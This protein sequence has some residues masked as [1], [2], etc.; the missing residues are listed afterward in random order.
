LRALRL[1]GS[2]LVSARTSLAPVMTALIAFCSSGD[3]GVRLTTCSW[4]T[5]GPIRSRIF[6]GSRPTLCSAEN[7]SMSSPRTIDFTR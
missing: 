4:M 1:A 5:I 2:L 6:S 3:M 7:R